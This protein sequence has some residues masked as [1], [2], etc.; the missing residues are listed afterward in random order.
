MHRH[1]REARGVTGA[2]FMWQLPWK[3]GIALLPGELLFIECS[4]C[5]ALCLHYVSARP[6]TARRGLGGWKPSPEVAG[7]DVNPVLLDFKV[8]DLI[9][10]GHCSPGCF[11]VDSLPSA[12]PRGLTKKP[13]G[14]D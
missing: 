1:H 14:L 5:Q 8:H 13:M 9:C 12:T 7:W 3:A 4:L 6:L 2:L 10:H 11:C